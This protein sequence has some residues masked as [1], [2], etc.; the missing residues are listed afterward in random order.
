MVAKQ[1]FKVGESSTA[2]VERSQIP[3]EFRGG[4]WVGGPSRGAGEGEGPQVA[5][6]GILCLFYSQG[7]G[8]GGL[9]SVLQERCRR[10]SPR[11]YLPPMV[12]LE[13]VGGHERN[14]AGGVGEPLPSPCWL[15]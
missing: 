15:S 9:T 4:N 8:L 12:G 1:V 11:Q 6:S 5:S 7:P 10:L 3:G 13:R 2:R 14:G